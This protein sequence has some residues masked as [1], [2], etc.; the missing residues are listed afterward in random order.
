MTNEENNNEEE[1]KKVYV[2]DELVKE[3]SGNEEIINFV[4]NKFKRMP[5]IMEWNTN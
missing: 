4:K 1:E 3:Y 2:D 5:I